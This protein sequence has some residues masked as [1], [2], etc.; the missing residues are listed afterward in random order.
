MNE[1]EQQH[2]RTTQSLNHGN[3]SSN[4]DGNTKGKTTVKEKQG[5]GSQRLL[6]HT[7]TQPAFWRMVMAVANQSMKTKERKEGKKR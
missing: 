5:G 3:H 2:T 6:L 7:T 1:T 4:S